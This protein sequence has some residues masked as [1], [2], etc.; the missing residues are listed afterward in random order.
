MTLGIA[1]GAIVP[2]AQAVTINQDALTTGLLFRGLDR[3]GLLPTSVTIPVPGVSG[4][5]VQLNLSYTQ[6]DPENLY[7]V[8]NGIPFPSAN[9]RFSQ[10]RNAAVIATG[11][12]ALDLV[13]TYRDQIA[14][15]QGN[16]PDGFTPFVP[17]PSTVLGTRQVNQTNQVLILVRNPLRPNGGIDARFP[18][19]FGLL[20]V[21]TSMPAAGVPS[22][23]SA[24]IK[25]NTGLLDLTYAYDPLSDFPATLNAF[26][27]LNSA[28]ATVPS[29]LTGGGEL[30]G[31]NINDIGVNLGT[32]LQLGVLAPNGQQWYLTFAPNNLPIV[33]PLRFP[34]RIFNRIAERLELPIRMGSP[35]ADILQPA[36]KILVNIGYTDVVTPDDIAEDPSLGDEYQPY[37]RTFTTSGVDTPFLSSR[38]LT[39]AEWLQ[40]PG[41]VIRALIGGINDE[42]RDIFNGGGLFYRVPPEDETSTPASGPA[43]AAVATAAPEPANTAAVSNE[44]TAK[45]ASAVT[46]NEVTTSNEV[47]DSN[48]G[49][50]TSSRSRQTP[51]K[52]SFTAAT[53]SAPALDES[54]TP[55][56]DSPADVDADLDADLDKGSG[57]G[58]DVARD[59]VT[60]ELTAVATHTAST[61]ASAGPTAQSGAVGSAHDGGP[62]AAGSARDCGAAAG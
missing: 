2:E 22:G 13:R 25:L 28:F 57:S 48:D 15:A 47:T 33:E 21:D 40:V 18:R 4:L 43:P 41:D 61:D 1:G 58:S 35:L 36:A 51:K 34:A 62:A 56:A 31:D 9:P 52:G 44:A 20:G 46:V 16:P 39:L 12:A 53:E 6:P 24:G 29:Y 59:G 50:G 30:K 8:I 60:H 5:E 42:I 55:D 32:I 49:A 17:N 37:D 7:E 38:P 10:S 14:A 3:A 45:T 19:I 26:S 23:Q 11:S 54:S 27:L